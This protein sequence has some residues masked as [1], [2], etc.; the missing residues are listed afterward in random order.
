MGYWASPH[1]EFGKL[2]VNTQSLTK[3]DYCE[4]FY[5]V[6][7]KSSDSFS[8]RPAR[9]QFAIYF[10]TTTERSPSKLFGDSEITFDVGMS[11]TRMITLDEPIDT[12]YPIESVYVKYKRVEKF[13]L[14]LFYADQ[15][16]FEYVEVF[17]GET[18]Q[19]IRYCPTADYIQSGQTLEFKKCSN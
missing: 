3:S 11:K 9:G 13:F 15:W 5:K 19:R 6:T 4:Q 14:G 12:K 2:F 16:G 1:K 17:N 18:Q 10:K 8:L 7:M